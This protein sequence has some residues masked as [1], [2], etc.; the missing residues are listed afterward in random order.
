ME[1]LEGEIRHYHWGDPSAIPELLG[2]HADG[3]PHAEL[4]FGAHPGGPSR[5]VDAGT[6]LD[7]AVAADP[8]GILGP[9]GGDDFPLL[10]KVLAAG[11]PLSL[12]VHPDAVQ[13]RAGFEREEAAGIPRDAPE[14]TYRDPHPKPEIVC[15]LTPF[16]AKCGLRA[17]DRTA[18]LLGCLRVEGL[19]PLVDVLSGPGDPAARLGG[20]VEWL[21]ALDPEAVADLVDEVTRAAA[22]VAV[23]GFEDELAWTGRLA[24]AYPGDVGVVVALLLNHV[25]LQPGQA[26]HLGAGNLHSYLEGV[27]VEVMA[28]SDNVVRG[29]LTSKH[30]DVDE[31]RRLLD[32]APMTPDVQSPS[33]PV[34]AYRVDSGAF[35]L[36]RAVLDGDGHV[37]VTGPGIALVTEGC[38][39]LR[40]GEPRRGDRTVD[41]TRGQAAL[42]RADDDGVTLAGEGVVHWAHGV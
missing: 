13:A 40:G 22:V 28:P 1:R 15:A 17:P 29:G 9:D 24:A 25:V 38:A 41:L 6:T 16:S 4:W 23:S 3:R 31:L 26:L 20:A 37:G 42:V 27:A 36:T 12:Q 21:F 2:R 8:E 33:G 10:A 11:G 14:R 32:T 19:G 30:V 18:V 5:L 35:G 39:Q 7:D 34:H